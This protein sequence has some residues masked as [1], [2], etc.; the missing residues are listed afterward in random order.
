MKKIFALLCFYLLITVV[1]SA[2]TI[3]GA[4]AIKNAQTG[5][6][7][8]IK[9][10]NGANGTPLVAYYPENWKC[11]TWDF[12]HIDGDTYEL[13]N[14]LS[15]KTFKPNGEITPGVALQEQ[16]LS[17]QT[18]EQQYTFELVSKNIYRIKLKGTE[19]YVTSSTEKESIDSQIILS[20]KSN[21]K[22]QQWTIYQ[23]S[24]TM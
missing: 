3:E 17:A 8:R 9:D 7:L 16:P 11:M 10:A 21:S 14:L 1:A 23:Q 13:K 6:L 20:A 15:G 18:N 12:E 5:M 22:T 24:P 2:Q 19:L 4:Y